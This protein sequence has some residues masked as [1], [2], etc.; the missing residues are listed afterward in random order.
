VGTG[1]SAADFATFDASS[2]LDGLFRA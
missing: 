2:Y 1:E